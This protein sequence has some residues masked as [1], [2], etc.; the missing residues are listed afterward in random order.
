MLLTVTICTPKYLCVQDNCLVIKDRHEDK[1]LDKI[2]L[3]DIW[4]IIIDNPQVSITAS[5]MGQVNDAGIGVLFCGSNHMPNGLALPIGAHSRHAE[6]VEHQLAISKPLRNQLWAK[7]VRRKIE[8]QARALELCGGKPCDVEKILSYARDVQ[9]NDKTHR[10]GAA[11]GE[12]FSK[13]LPYGSRWTAPMTAPLNF[14]YAILRTGIAQ[15]AVSHG[16]LVS[17]GIHHH[18][19]ENAFNLVDDLIEP[20]RAVVD[21]MVVKENLLAPLSRLN[22]DTLTKATSV[23]VLLDNKEMPVQTAIDVYCE[24]L[25]RAIELQD[26]DQLLLPTLIG[27]EMA[28]PDSLRTKGR[29]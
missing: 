4:V 29:L 19:A 20:F 15:C 11:A 23:L 5:L 21:L 2:P 14:G 16:W 1:V 10:E 18:S 7:I 13:L 27:L 17:R 22:K 25:R 12:Y 6:I 9:S 28:T 3:S 26:S 24:S 8:N